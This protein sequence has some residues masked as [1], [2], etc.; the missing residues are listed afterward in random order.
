M[1][2]AHAEPAVE[3]AEAPEIHDEVVD[4]AAAPIDP[5]ALRVWI[6]AAR[7]P[8]LV[9]MEAAGIVV[10]DEPDGASYAIVS[11]R[12]ARHRIT[13]YTA[14]AAEGGLAVVVLVHPGG[15]SVAVEALR[16][17]GHVAIAEGDSD[18][19][20]ALSIDVDL[21]GEK[22]NALLDAYE[23]RLG[24]NQTVVKSNVA[25]F[26]PVSGLPAA[27]A[28]T[29][30]VN[31]GNGDPDQNLRVV[32]ITVAGL[33]DPVRLRLGADGHALLHRRIATAIRLMCQPLGELYDD[34][35]GSFLL[36]APHLSSDATDRLGRTLSDIVGA[37]S[38]D[39]H[40][41][42]TIALGHAGPEC[43]S[44]LS[45]LRELAGR[46]ESAA[47]LEE[48]SAVLGAGELVGPLATATELEVT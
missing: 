17:G 24:R 33:F 31:S 18:A 4:E 42:M 12:L 8:V 43:S 36:L 11:T 28:L 5:N 10:I 2:A 39:G 3:T 34:G 47:S 44:D 16:A 9:A 40:M 20:R 29:A 45:T 46:A 22:I 35:D 1:T 30:R 7:L 26:D 21:D 14:Q 27:G 13:E 23:A 38:P 32:A 37:Y 19:L 25:M 48:R 41:P 15:E 6:P